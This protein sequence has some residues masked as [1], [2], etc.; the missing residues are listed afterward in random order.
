MTPLEE[1]IFREQ[2]DKGFGSRGF[3][4]HKNCTGCGKSF[5]HYQLKKRMARHKFDKTTWHCVT[6]MEKKAA[7]DS[8]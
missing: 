3:S 7:N 1:Q 2:T 4:M 5:P 8:R 6:C